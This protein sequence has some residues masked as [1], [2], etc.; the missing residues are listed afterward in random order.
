MGESAGFTFPDEGLL[1]DWMADS[2]GGVDGGLNVARG[3]GRWPV[4]IELER[5][6][7]RSRALEEVISVTAAI[8]RIG[9]PAAW[10]RTRHCLG[11]RPRQTGTHGN[12]GKFHLRQRR[13]RKQPVGSGTR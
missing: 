6:A 10:P 2:A 1:E 13:D 8:R 3:R 7:G 9:A 12:G 4:E 11:T 5:D